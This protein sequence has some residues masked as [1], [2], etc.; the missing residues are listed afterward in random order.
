MPEA[1]A[2]SPLME[3]LRGRFDLILAT[4]SEVPEVDVA[5]ELTRLQ[6]THG[7]TAWTTANEV[8]ASWLPPGRIAP[9]EYVALAARP[10]EERLLCVELAVL[11]VAETGSLLTHG[12]RQQRRLPML[13]DVQVLLVRA[14]DVVPDLDAAAMFIDA[15][16]PPPPYISFVTGASRTSDIE[17]TLT[18]GV[19]GPS[20]LHVVVVEG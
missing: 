15:M 9:D 20:R 6:E 11:A 4:W 3:R 14:E 18:I 7:A 12:S 19:H 13:S 2:M 1:G 8:P 16:T 10:G 5:A 17:R